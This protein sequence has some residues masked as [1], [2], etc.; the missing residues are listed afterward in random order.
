MKLSL[1]SIQQINALAITPDKRFVASA[2]YQHIRMYEVNSS[3]TS[4]VSLW[5]VRTASYSLLHCISLIRSLLC[6]TGC[7]P[8]SG[9]L[10]SL[11]LI[12]RV[13]TADYVG[14]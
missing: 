10:F 2:G 4:A 9:V 1:P 7:Y 5:E 11:G 12:L 13:A 3:E 14:L 8:D 6:F